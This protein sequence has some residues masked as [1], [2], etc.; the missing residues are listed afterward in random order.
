MRVRWEVDDGY[1]GKSRPH[2]VD[3]PD[4]ELADCE[5]REDQ[6][7]LV[8]QCV[9]EAFEEKV[10]YYWKAEGEYPKP[11]S[12]VYEGVGFDEEQEDKEIL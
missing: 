2:F 5:S 8:E 4:D 3:V 11:G 10:A 6:E 9:L 12:S 7:A 1:A